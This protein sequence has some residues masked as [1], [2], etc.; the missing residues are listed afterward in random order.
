M[1][2][3]AVRLE[4]LDTD[5][6]DYSS[7]RILS[8]AVERRWE[9]AARHARRDV[10]VYLRMNPFPEKELEDTSFHSLITWA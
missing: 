8:D 7:S 9:N 10:L 4:H 3:H 2:R 6:H 1:T 5:L